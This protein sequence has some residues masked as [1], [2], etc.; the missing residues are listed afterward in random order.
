MILHACYDRSL[1]RSWSTLQT[2][3]G[4]SCMCKSGAVGERSFSAARKLKTWLRSTMTQERF[5]NLKQPQKEN[6]QIC[7][8]DVANILKFAVRNYKTGKKFRYIK[9]PPS[10]FPPPPPQ[11]RF[12]GSGHRPPHFKNCSFRGPCKRLS[13]ATGKVFY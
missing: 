6:R 5:S 9:S 1:K 4:K 8:T 3:M 11:P 12:K 10:S 7:L 2:S 13:K